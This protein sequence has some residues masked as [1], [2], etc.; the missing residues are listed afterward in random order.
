MV[1]LR[2]EL[3]S[4]APSAHLEALAV[5]EGFEGRGLGGRLLAAA[6]SDAGEQGA[7]SLTLHVFAVNE[8]ARR[9]YEKAGFEGEL[10][11]YIKE[12]PGAT[13]S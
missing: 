5:A 13:G 6:E 1:T 10:M 7:Q 9:L 8:R 3:L 12:L 2:P 11:R 4:R